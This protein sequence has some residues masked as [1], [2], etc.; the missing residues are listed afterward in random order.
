MTIHGPAKINMRFRHHQLGI[1][2]DARIDDGAWQSVDLIPARNFATIEEQW[3][4]PAKYMEAIKR[5]G[6]NVTESK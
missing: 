6:F 4:F 5:K 1:D 3:A 2:I